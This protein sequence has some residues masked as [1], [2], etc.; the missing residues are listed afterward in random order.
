MEAIASYIPYGGAILIIIMLLN[1]THQG[2]LFHWMD[3]NLTDPNSPE[4]DVILFEK[5]RFLNIKITL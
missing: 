3:P 4:F 2:H 5:K 1:I